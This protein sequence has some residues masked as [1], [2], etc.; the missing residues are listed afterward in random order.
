MNN[1][2]SSSYFIG[3][4]VGT[5][6]V[7]AA[8]FSESGKRL[9]LAVFPIK[10]FR[11]KENFVEQSSEDIWIKTCKAINKAV[12]EASVPISSIK[13][14]GF[15]ATCSLVALGNGF[16]QISV[17]PTRSEEQN[18]IVWMDHRALKETVEINETED[19]VLKYVG[20]R[21]SPEMEIP[22]ILWVKRNLPKQYQKIRKFLDLADYMVYRSSGTDIRSV[23]TMTCKWTYLAHEKRW[24]DSLFKSIDLEDLFEEK[25]I[26]SKI[27]E[28]GMPAGYLTKEAA[29]DFG[30]TTN[31]VVAVG[32]IDAHS[33]GLGMVGLDPEHSLSIIAGTSSC[34]M[35]ISKNPLFIQGV[36][37]PYYGVILPG[38][39]LNEGGQS[40]A[41]ALLDHIVSDSACFSKLKQEAE[42]RGDSPYRLL[43][44]LIWQMEKEDPYITKNFHLLGYFH[45]NR[46]PRANPYLKGMISGLTLN[47]TKEELAKKYLA[48]IQSVAYGTRHIIKAL[49][50]AGHQIKKIH[51]CG[52]TA[53]DKIWLREHADITDCEIGLP[54]DLESVLMGGAMLAATASG[55][56]PNLYAAIQG[57]WAMGEKVLPRD[58]FKDYHDKKYKVFH[59]M[60]HDQIK[61]ND[62]MK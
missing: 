53:K 28:V 45:G 36:W 55:N 1:M 31:T 15:D 62:M 58:S 19:E 21:I 54:Q 25:R 11:P 61:Y 22:K 4:D 34:H 60:Y 18:I 43:D 23:C 6:S 35:A 7:R 38:M 3:V 46:S 24:S 51:M 41:G 39:W 29:N 57:M 37:G 14:I 48:A 9:S 26:G 47:Q 2:R 8:V 30:L 56:F 12:N 40:T 42:Q 20:G 5:G 32:I 33:G 49:N 27:E 16:N 52:G 13:G 17:S 59:E 50:E 10:I 44:E